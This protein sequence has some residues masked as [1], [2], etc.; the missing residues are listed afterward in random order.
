MSSLYHDA[1]EEAHH[2]QAMRSIAAE[3]GR[4][5]E[6]VKQVYEQQLADLSRG[7]HVRSYLPLLA[8]RRTL[9]ALGAHEAAARS[10][11]HAH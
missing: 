3:T 10:G 2:L 8:S 6:T 11:S 7:A 1:D 4:E 9:V 5:L